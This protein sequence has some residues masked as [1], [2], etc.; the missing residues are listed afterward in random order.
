MK[1]VWSIACYEF[2]IQRR[3][4]A[5]W[6]V[7]VFLTAFLF[8]EILPGISSGAGL[9]SGQNPFLV[10]FFGTEAQETM[11]VASFSIFQ[12][13]RISDLLGLM[14]ALFISILGAFVWQRDGQFAITEMLNTL[15]YQSWQYILGKYLGV[16]CSWGVIV[17]PMAAIGM[18]WTYVEAS[19]YGLTFMLADFLM[20]LA[21][22]MLLSLAYGTAFVMAAS[23]IVRNGAATLLLYF[24]YWAYCIM[25]VGMLQGASTAKLFSYWLIRSGVTIARDS[26]L[27]VQARLPVLLLNR[28]LYLTLAA[29]ILWL[30]ARLFTHF[31]RQGSL[32]GAGGD[33]D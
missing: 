16:V 20:P 2:K 18:V 30:I 7:A 12:A 31:R 8:G 4:L 13:W 25:D 26:L 5:F 1:T 14:A 21:G 27:L 29:V 33:A 32:L 22:W 19:R 6:L 3:S 17:A 23:L 15:P 11:K 9:A 24:F 28:C 10:E